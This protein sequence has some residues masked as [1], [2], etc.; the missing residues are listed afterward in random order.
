MLADVASI[1]TYG[2]QTEDEEQK[3]LYEDA[4]EWIHSDDSDCFSFNYVCEA[5][6]VEPDK[7]RNRLCTLKK[8]DKSLMW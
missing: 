5:L 1:L 2:K 7:L 4:F 8:F 6:E 3:E